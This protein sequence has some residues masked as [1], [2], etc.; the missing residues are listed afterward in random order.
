[1]ATKQGKIKSVPV[2]EVT[3]G[4]QV[5]WKN[6]LIAKVCKIGDTRSPKENNIGLTKD[7]RY[8]VNIMY[9]NISELTTLI[10]EYE[11]T[12]EVIKENW[13]YF[14]HTFPI[15]KREYWKEI[16]KLATKAYYQYELD[17]KNTKFCEPP[18]LYTYT[19][20]PDYDLK[21][22]TKQIPLK[23]KQW[24][25]A[26]DKGQVN[27]TAEVEFE[28]IVRDEIAIEIAHSE[29]NHSKAEALRNSPPVYA[30]VV[31]HNRVPSMEDII[32]LVYRFNQ[33]KGKYQVSKETISEWVNDHF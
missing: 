6:K 23:N 29:G 15:N 8:A 17:L 25:K 10:V 1:M 9:C 30:K 16:P 7:G 18:H 24:Q 28:I 11:D 20:I 19:F 3:V 32:D 13:I 31:P 12:A 33:E 26:I 27:G 2:K 22:H 14:G 21:I 4:M 5:M